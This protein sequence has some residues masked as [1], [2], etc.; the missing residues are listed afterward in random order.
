MQGEPMPAAAVSLGSLVLMRVDKQSSTR[1][2]GTIKT[3]VAMGLGIA[4]PCDSLNGFHLF[5]ILEKPPTPRT[6]Q[7]CLHNSGG[8]TVDDCFSVIFEVGLQWHQDRK[9]RN[10]LRKRSQR[11]STSGRWLLLEAVIH[12]VCFGPQTELN[13]LHLD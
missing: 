2:K 10:W 12:H 5:K 8:F 9:T 3:E 7:C 6:Q 4:D 1:A 11:P 13:R